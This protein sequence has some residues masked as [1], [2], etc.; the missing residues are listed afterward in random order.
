[1][2]ARFE[3]GDALIVVDVQRDFCPGGA[4]PVPAGD[5]IIPVLNSWMQSAVAAGAPVYASRDW[6][7]R[8][9]ISF[10]ERGGPWPP[11]CVQDTRG[12]EFHPDLRLPAT[13]RIVTKG[14]RFDKDQNSAFDDTGL[15]AELRRD[16]ISRIWVAGLAQDICVQATI[17]DG[18]KEGFRVHL[19]AAGTRP[20]QPERAGQ[21]LQE[22]IRAGARVEEET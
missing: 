9:H 16:G 1:M 14:V 6:H 4:L 17:L 13:A 3:K 20:V 19:I 22:L 5:E 2:A 8:G 15:A 10:Q 12:A 7:P 21:V 11:H 18:L